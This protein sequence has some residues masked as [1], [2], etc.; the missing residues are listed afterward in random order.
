MSIQNDVCRHFGVQNMNFEEI[1]F[2][3]V[4][5]VRKDTEFSMQL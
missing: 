1:Q 3:I 4:L 2:I 5:F